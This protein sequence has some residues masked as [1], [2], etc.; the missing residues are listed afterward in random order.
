M[1]KEKTLPYWLAGGTDICAFCAQPHAV[2]VEYRCAGCD[3]AGCE[4]C[5]VIVRA[6][7]EALCRECLEEDEAG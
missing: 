2:Q 4:H 7:G 5:V 6:T 1:A 3:R